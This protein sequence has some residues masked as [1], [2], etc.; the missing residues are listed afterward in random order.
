MTIDTLNILLVLI[1]IL[2]I[3]QAQF[4]A[5][6]HIAWLRVNIAACDAPSADSLFAPYKDIV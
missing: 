2:D 3:Q 6:H 5:R 1:N 4:Y